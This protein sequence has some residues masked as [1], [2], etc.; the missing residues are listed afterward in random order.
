M[1]YTIGNPEVYEPY[2]DTPSPKKGTG[3][4]VWCT[5]DDVRAYLD[6]PTMRPPL[7]SMVYWPNGMMHK[8]SPIR[9]GGHWWNLLGS[10]GWKR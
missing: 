8:K 7:A 1:I 6:N 10:S 5:L 3:G 9:S 4:S 2:L